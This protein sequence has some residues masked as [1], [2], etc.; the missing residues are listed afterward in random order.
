MPAS[1][2]QPWECILPLNPSNNKAWPSDTLLA[3]HTDTLG[4]PIQCKFSSLL[5]L[6]GNDFHFDTL[7][8]LVGVTLVL[9]AETS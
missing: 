4:S 9:G 1:P 2:S 3:S 8:S 7:K 6:I 5:A